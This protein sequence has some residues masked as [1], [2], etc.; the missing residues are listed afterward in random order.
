MFGVYTLGLAGRGANALGGKPEA[1][2]VLFDG[3]SPG[4]IYNRSNFAPLY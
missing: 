1:H 3:I 2:P 4:V